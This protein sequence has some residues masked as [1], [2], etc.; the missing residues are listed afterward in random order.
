M[1]NFWL[2]NLLGHKVTTGLQKVKKN[3]CVTWL[4][5]TRLLL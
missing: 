4:Q 1:S 2:L 5:M 3:V